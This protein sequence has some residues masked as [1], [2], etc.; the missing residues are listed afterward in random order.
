MQDAG[1]FLKSVDPLAAL[2]FYLRVRE[3][4]T[5][6]TPLRQPPRPISTLQA[7]SIEGNASSAATI[8]ATL[9]NSGVCPLNGRRALNLTTVKSTISL[10]FCCGMSD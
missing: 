1:V 3:P 5:G 10:M 6:H 9:T 7:C 4:A 8:A 2:D